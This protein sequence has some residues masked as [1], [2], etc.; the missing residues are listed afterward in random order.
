MSRDAA[1]VVTRYVEAVANGDR[2]VAEWTSRGTAR[3]GRAYDNP[4][5]GVFTV[6]GGKITSVREYTD[7]QHVEHALFAPE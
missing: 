7:T 3:N 4:C 5:L 6:R 1:L 2:V